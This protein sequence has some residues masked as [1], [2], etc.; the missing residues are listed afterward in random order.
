M[1]TTRRSN[2]NNFLTWQRVVGDL[3]L[4]ELQASG[5]PTGT[6]FIIV[7]QSD[8]T[9]TSANDGF[10]IPTTGTG[11]NYDVVTDEGHEWHNQT[12]DVLVDF[13]TA[14]R[15]E[16][17]ISGDFPRIYFNNGG[18]KLTLLTITQWGSIAWSSFLSA[19]VGCTNLDVKT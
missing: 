6:D 7:V 16:I 15:H 12:G 10:H 14:G 5:I 13:D 9:G 19:F 17:R 11:Y 4:A 3:T 1:A 2:K 18:D 8:N